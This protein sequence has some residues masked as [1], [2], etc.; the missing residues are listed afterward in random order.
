MTT[1]SLIIKS[2]AELAVVVFLIIGF[3]NENK[4]V[5]FERTCARLI[6]AY[7]RK[8]RAAKAAERRVERDL[9]SEYETERRSAVRDTEQSGRQHRQHSRKVA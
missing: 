3:L 2:A 1:T 6:R 5:K 4:F 7:M 9:I 8:R